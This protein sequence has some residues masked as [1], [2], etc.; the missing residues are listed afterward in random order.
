MAERAHPELAVRKVD[1]MRCCMDLLLSA[2]PL[3]VNYT[4]SDMQV[5][6]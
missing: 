3:Y 4:S 2:L 1:S 6:R 5:N